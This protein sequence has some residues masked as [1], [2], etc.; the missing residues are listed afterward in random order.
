[1]DRFVLDLPITDGVLQLTLLVAAALTVPL[2]HG[3]IRRI[4]PFPAPAPG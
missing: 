4:E 1:M 2:T 3:W